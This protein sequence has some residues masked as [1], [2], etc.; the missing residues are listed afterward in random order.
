MGVSGREGKKLKRERE[1]E[2]E[3]GGMRSVREKEPKRERGKLKLISFPFFCSSLHI[4]ST[5]QLSEM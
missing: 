5:W 2:S 1:R 4:V 3:V